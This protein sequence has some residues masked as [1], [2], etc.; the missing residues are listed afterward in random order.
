MEEEVIWY[1][2]D[3][4]LRLTLEYM[5]STF[6]VSCEENAK[7]ALIMITKI[8]QKC[9][10]LPCTKTW[11]AVFR[12]RAVQ[13]KALQNFTK[14]SSGIPFG[15]TTRYKKICHNRIHGHNMLQFGGKKAEPF[16]FH[17]RTCTNLAGRGIPFSAA[18]NLFTVYLV[19]ATVFRAGIWFIRL[20]P[21]RRTLRV[22]F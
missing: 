14:T 3:L 16:R 22:A 21:R 13:T 11:F 2:Q 1:F 7:H 17:R 10:L 15:D 12:P 9:Q 4:D 18:R 8:L 5:L 6:V 19:T 20:F